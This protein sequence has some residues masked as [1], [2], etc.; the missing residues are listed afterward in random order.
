[1]KKIFSFLAVLLLAVSVNAASVWTET[2]DRNGTY[3]DKTEKGYWPY[4]SQWFEGYTGTDGEVDGNQYTTDYES[5]T[6]KNVTIRGKKVD[7][8]SKS[9]PGLYFAANKECTVSFTGL[10]VEV[11]EGYVLLFTF[12]NPQDATKINCNVLTVKVNGTAVSVPS[13]ETTGE[14]KSSVAMMDLDVQTV[15]SLEISMG[16]QANPLFINKMEIG[17]GATPLF[18][19][20]ADKVQAVKRIENG[21]VV[22]IRNGVKYNAIG[23]VVE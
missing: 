16:S 18:S 15:N 10:D 23:A 14:L 19:V 20:F 11:P 3:I 2:F 8:A 9:L 12:C 6:S 4:A 13:V 1:M 17:D 22:F 7:G 21:Q 5:V